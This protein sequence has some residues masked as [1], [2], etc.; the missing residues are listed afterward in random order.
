MII[1]EN[2]SI[3]FN[4]NDIKNNNLINNYNIIDF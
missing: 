4:I 1:I 3:G 2:G